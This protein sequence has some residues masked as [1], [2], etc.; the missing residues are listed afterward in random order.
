MAVVVWLG[1]AGY[2]AFHNPIASSEEAQKITFASWVGQQPLRETFFNIHEEFGHYCIFQVLTYA[3]TKLLDLAS[4]DQFLI[5]ARALNIIFGLLSVFILRFIFYQNF[6]R[7]NPDYLSILTLFHPLFFFY[8]MQAEEYA[9]FLFFST[10]QLW[11]YL[12][13]GKSRFAPIIFLVAS[14]F[15]YYTSLLFLVLLGAEC[16]TEI[17][18]CFQIKRISIW[19]FLIAGLLAINVLSQATNLLSA[20]WS[21]NSALPYINYYDE[22]SP[23]NLFSYLNILGAFWGITPLF[24][25]PPALIMLT[26]LLVGY[27]FYTLW[28]EHRK[29][30]VVFGV[31]YCL[32][33]FVFFVWNSWAAF[34]SFLYPVSMRYFLPLAFLNILILFGQQFTKTKIWLA[35]CLL[36]VFITTNILIIGRPYNMLVRGWLDEQIADNH[37]YFVLIIF[38][39]RRAV[40]IAF[41]LILL[42]LPL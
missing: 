13:F 21:L 15:G 26:I 36:A 22:F 1:L 17:I 24:F 10:L 19:P 14:V 12:D 42:T 40:S 7:S 23:V 27:S 5:I 16:L 37:S 20:H 4:L 32:L 2:G 25:I 41:F 34:A 35:I 11:A 18:K 33:F 3:V 28:L 6:S 29:I 30:P 39:A 38:S 9:L 8:S 31:Y